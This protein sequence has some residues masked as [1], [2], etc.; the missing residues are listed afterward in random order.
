DV[1]PGMLTKAGCEGASHLP[2]E[3]KDLPR[4]RLDQVGLQIGSRGQ[5]LVGTEE[6]AADGELLHLT[7][8]H[9]RSGTHV[10]RDSVH[11]QPRMTP[12]VVLRHGPS[13]AG[14]APTIDSVVR[15]RRASNRS[16][17][18][19]VGPLRLYRNAVASVHT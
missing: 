4:A 6:G 11:P 3:V 12:L 15:S 19:G 7:G 14:K 10:R 18:V 1:Q 9:N 16:G 17:C 2:A 13:V 5:E 8:E